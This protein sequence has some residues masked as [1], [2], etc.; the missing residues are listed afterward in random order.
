MEDD[1][2]I[3]RPPT[4]STTPGLGVT[5]LASSTTAAKEDISNLLRLYGK[6]LVFKNESATAGDAIFINFS[7]DGVTD[8][9]AAASAGTTFALG[10]TAAQGYKLN[11]GDEIVLR[12]NRAEH[13]FLHWDALANTPVLS[14]YPASKGVNGN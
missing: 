11:P 14:I 5:R 4:Q 10:T 6:R 7:A 13:K 9:S 2:N 3:L 8:V 12:L 1:K